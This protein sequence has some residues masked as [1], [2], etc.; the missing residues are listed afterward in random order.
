MPVMILIGPTYRKLRTEIGSKLINDKYTSRLRYFRV[1]SQSTN[2]VRKA[3]RRNILSD[4]IPRGS[5]VW[6]LLMKF[7][8]RSYVTWEHTNFIA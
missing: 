7:I 4:C 1:L 3:A 5:T 6:S 8:E 2:I